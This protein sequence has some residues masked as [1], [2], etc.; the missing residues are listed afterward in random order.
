ML[1]HTLHSG[2]EYLASVCKRF[3]DLNK[4]KNHICIVRE[5]NPGRPRGRRAFYHWTNDADMFVFV[6][7]MTLSIYT[8]QPRAR[9]L[10][11]SFFPVACPCFFRRSYK[12]VAVGDGGWPKPQARARR[13]GHRRLLSTTRIR[14]T[15]SDEATITRR[16][17]KK[18]SLNWS[19]KP[20]E[21]LLLYHNYRI[22]WV[23]FYLLIRAFPIGTA[24]YREEFENV[25]TT[26]PTWKWTQIK[27]ITEENADSSQHTYYRTVLPSSLA[28]FLR[29]T[30]QNRMER[31]T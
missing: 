9:L 31:R 7:T 10:Q 19:Q 23:K 26:V 3:S 6:W 5:S 16:G 2:K 24:T 20:M 11:N 15:P 18:D 27:V 4:F 21:T 1:V 13:M 12:I 14:F 8:E 30:E 17:W 22:A 28:N 25:L 29:L